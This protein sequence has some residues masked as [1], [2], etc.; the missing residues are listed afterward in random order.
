MASPK[1]EM[2]YDEKDEIVQRVRV[3]LLGGNVVGV[4]QGGDWRGGGG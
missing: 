1:R 4:W 2:I 3:L